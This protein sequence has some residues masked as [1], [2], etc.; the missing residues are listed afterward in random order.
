MYEIIDIYE[1][2]S[3]IFKNIGN[4]IEKIIDENLYPTCFQSEFKKSIRLSN[5]V[6][7]KLHQPAASPAA[8]H[9][10]YSI[11]ED[12][13]DGDIQ[14]LLGAAEKD[15]MNSNVHIQKNKKVKFSNIKY[16]YLIPFYY[17][18]IKSLDDIWW[19]END[20]LNACHDA[21]KKIKNLLDIHPLMTHK[22]AKKILY[23]PF[24]YDESN[25]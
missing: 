25:F 10:R 2:N 12:R 3:E 18:I 14:A 5:G 20:F 15:Y 1:I 21:T 23:S 7:R 17:E 4:N 11:S 24:S 9:S 22:Q 13:N 8:P 19:N 6:F 16:I